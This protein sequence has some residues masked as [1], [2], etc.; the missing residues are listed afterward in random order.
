V[1]ETDYVIATEPLFVGVAR[2][3]NV[4]DRVPRVN[5]E[6]NGWQDAVAEP[7]SGDAGQALASLADAPGLYDPSA[8]KVDEVLTYLETADVTEQQRVLAAERAGGNRK[9]ILGES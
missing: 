2:A 6:Q 4:G 9:G 5:V 7:D 3:H 8:H 1:T